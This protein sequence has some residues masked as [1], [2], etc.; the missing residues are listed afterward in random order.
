METHAAVLFGTNNLKLESLTI[1]AL[2]QGQ[3][4]V[5]MAYSGICRSQLLEIKGDRGVDKF[6]PHTLGH[7]G[8][9]IVVQIGQDVK[10]VKIGDHVV[11]TWI[12]GEGWDVPSTMYSQ[13]STMVNSGAISTFMTTTVISE[14]RVVSIPDKMPLRE[15][16]L[17][18]C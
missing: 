14:N 12:K 1:P 4:L 3:V 15:A 8:S 10:K 2:K 13:G 6:L 17:L 11:V 18:G 16:A 9:G 7:E 5:Q